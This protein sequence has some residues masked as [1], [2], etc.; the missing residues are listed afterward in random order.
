[1]RKFLAHRWLHA[2][3]FGVITI[4]FGFVGISEKNA[5]LDTA[6]VFYHTFRLFK[7]DM[8]PELITEVGWKLEIAR[9]L[10][11][12]VAAFAALVGLAE[13]FRDQARALALRLLRGHVVICGLG[14]EG[15]ALARNMSTQYRTVVIEVDDGNEHLPACVDLGSAVLVGDATDPEILHK[16]RVMRAR[17]VIIVC[18][19]DGINVEIAVKIYEK[20]KGA[21]TRTSWG[22]RRRPADIRC[23]VHVVDPKLCTSF[24]RH[25]IFTDRDDPLKVEI[26]NAFELSSR[27]LLQER[28]LDRRRIG[29]NDS[30]V[31]HLIVVGYGR[32]GENVALQAAH[33][34]HFANEKKLRITVIDRDMVARRR[35]F[36]SRY[37]TF[38]QVCD[39]EWIDSEVEDEDLL[40]RLE[41]FAGD[42]GTLTTLVICFD[43]DTHGLSTALLLNTR[44]RS[45]DVPILVRMAHGVE[46]GL[47]SLVAGHEEMEKN[48]LAC[49]RPPTRKRICATKAS[50]RSP[51]RFTA[52]TS[53]RYRPGA[54]RSARPNQPFESGSICSP[55]TATPTA[56]RPITST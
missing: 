8:A 50:I 35:N 37:P 9:F 53:Q 31:V 12:V 19:D 39:C 22:L 1:M 11:P 44:L 27:L 20:A 5:N 52:T 15:V 45:Y 26:F 42:E 40:T 2:G 24:R 13:V 38:E 25:P 49:S 4:G 41:S 54:K 28:P 48:P 46:R 17:S 18:G 56:S 23:L 30:T 16:A 14:R 21:S 6:E 10:G 3:I 32:M 7:M 43:D 36:R 55:S 47:T 34:G 33:L 29:P 51:S